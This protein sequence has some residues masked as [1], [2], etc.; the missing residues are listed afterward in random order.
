MSKKK[1][2]MYR[3][4]LIIFS[5]IS[6]EAIASGFESAI[7]IILKH[8]GK[9]SDDPSD[10]GGITKYGIS[11]RYLKQLIASRPDLMSNYDLSHDKIINDYDIA[12]MSIEEARE[13]YRTQFWD[14]LKIGRI[15]NQRIATKVLDMSVNMGTSRAIKLLQQACGK[16]SGSNHLA[17]NGT[18][19]NETVGF[20][21]ELDGKQEKRLL[22]LLRIVSKEYYMYI[23]TKHPTYKRFLAGWLRRGKE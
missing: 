12:N 6:M 1:K 11:L 17:I 4:I 19:D 9:L 5:L 14:K 21:N 15:N 3:L 13:L 20:I 23:A 7:P 8:E 18:L 2:Y 22:E 16:L 10:K